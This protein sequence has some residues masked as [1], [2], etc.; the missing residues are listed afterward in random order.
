MRKG[1]EVCAVVQ[2]CVAFLLLD[3]C[4]VW[5]AF[6]FGFC[7]RASVVFHHGELA[8]Y[9]ELNMDPIHTPSVPKYVVTSSFCMHSLIAVFSF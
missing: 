9:G 4:N 6:C 1:L 2:L 5:G 7:L 8:L 3:R